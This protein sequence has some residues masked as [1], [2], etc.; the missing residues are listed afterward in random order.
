V[1]ILQQEAAFIRIRSGA[2]SAAQTQKSSYTNGRDL[3]G[4]SNP[5]CCWGDGALSFLG[6]FCSWEAS[7]KQQAN[8]CMRL[9]A[10]DDFFAV[11]FS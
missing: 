9:W 8:S 2:Q 4:Y 5:I 11:M 6:K 1:E 7:S 3:P 10:M